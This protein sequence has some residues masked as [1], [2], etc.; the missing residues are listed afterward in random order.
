MTTKVSSS[1]LV[2]Y[3]TSGRWFTLPNLRL[4]PS[5]PFWLLAN[6][7]A[8]PP[9]KFK[10]LHYLLNTREKARKTRSGSLAA[11]SILWSCV[12]QNL[13][14]VNTS[15]IAKIGLALVFQSSTVEAAKT[16]IPPRHYWTSTRCTAPSSEWE[17]SP[18]RGTLSW[19]IFNVVELFAQS[20]ICSLIS[21]ILISMLLR[22]RAV[23][24]LQTFNYIWRSGVAA[25][26]S[27][28]NW[29]RCCL[30]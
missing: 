20:C 21:K 14:F 17:E 2:C 3:A 26:T 11:T 29:T 28:I 4:V 27:Q 7:S 6:L 15:H 12:I 23:K 18:E 25:Y 13:V 22:P 16:S 10:I 1:S 24:F 8:L 9:E 5:S 30:R 19:E